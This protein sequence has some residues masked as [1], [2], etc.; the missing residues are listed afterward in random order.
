MP[1]PSPRILDAR[2]AQLELDRMRLLAALG[3]ARGNQ[4]RTAA[5]LGYSLATLKRRLLAAGLTAEELRERWPLAARQPRRG[6]RIWR[7][8]AGRTYTELARKGDEVQLVRRGREGE[9]RPTWW[10]L[11]EIAAK[12][13][14]PS[15]EKSTDR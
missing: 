1:A 4:V 14:A 6:E 11:G 8:A 7:D 12:G 2:R 9:D 5:A 15:R 10:T 3:R 13:L